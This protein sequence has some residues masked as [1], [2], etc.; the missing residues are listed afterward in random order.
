M[1]CTATTT[2][3]ARTM[4]HRPARSAEATAFRTRRDRSGTSGAAPTR[5]PRRRL[6]VGGAV[7][8]DRQSRRSGRGGRR[9]A[10]GSTPASSP[11][12]A[13]RDRR[14]RHARHSSHAV[15]GR[16]RPGVASSRSAV[17]PACGAGARRRATAMMAAMAAHRRSLAALRRRRARG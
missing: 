7:A 1:I 13:R 12:S 15:T 8:N 4:L 10:R 2:S 6:G 3:R 9:A 16:R 11:S 17:S 5:W 14:S